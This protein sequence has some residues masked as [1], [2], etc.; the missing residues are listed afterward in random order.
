MEFASEPTEG[1]WYRLRHL[2]TGRYIAT[3]FNDNFESGAK[4][5]ARPPS[6]PGSRGAGGADG[7]Q[8]L[9]TTRPIKSQ[10]LT[11]ITFTSAKTQRSDSTAKPVL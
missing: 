6:R 4:G 8:Y 1:P 3:R 11:E 10:K 7:T 5:G 2:N 9:C